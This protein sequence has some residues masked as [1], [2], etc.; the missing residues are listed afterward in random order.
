MQGL[1]LNGLSTGINA[2]A[3]LAGGFAQYQAARANAAYATANAQSTLT[4]AAQAEEASNARYRAAI[5]EQLAAQG[6]SGFAMGTGSALDALTASR[7]NE[8]Q[9]AMDINR[10]AQVRA[11]IYDAQ[12]SMYR[13]SATMGLFSGILKGASTLLNNRIDYAN[14]NAAAGFDPRAPAGAIQPTI[15]DGS[16]GT[17]GR[18]MQFGPIVADPSAPIQF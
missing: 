2:G 1:D 5:G 12:A 3:Q 13:R 6:A 4:D 14:A 17:F 16:G 8:A 9:A 15:A 18:S 11:Q 7:V 10:Q